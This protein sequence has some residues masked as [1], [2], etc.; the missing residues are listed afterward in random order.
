MRRALAVVLAGVAV[1]VAAPAY[2]GQLEKADREVDRA[3]LSYAEPFPT[4]KHPNRQYFEMTD[5][6][7][8]I[9][10]GTLACLHD[11]RVRDSICIRVFWYAR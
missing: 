6:R 11:N 3:Y 1:T 9:Y 4:K 5:G 10:K 2:A 7:A 8:F